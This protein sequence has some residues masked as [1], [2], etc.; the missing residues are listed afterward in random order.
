MTRGKRGQA[1]AP[2]SLFSFQDIMTSVMGIL[3]LIT[4]MMSLELQ[5]TVE[6]VQTPAPQTATPPPETTVAELKQKREQLQAQYEKAVAELSA[7]AEMTGDK[8]SVLRE[9]L[10]RLQTTITEMEQ[11]E[12]RVREIQ[13]QTEELAKQEKSM[14]EKMQETVALEQRASQLRGEIDRLKS[15]PRLTYIMQQGAG[16]SPIL[17]ELSGQLLGIGSH[18][19][20]EPAMWADAKDIDG[21]IELLL[22]LAGNY[23][24]STEYFVLLVK[25]SGFEHYRQVREKLAEKGFDVGTELLDENQYVLLRSE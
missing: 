19:T 11:L 23:S 8:S 22:A 20:Q 12:R 4:L 1:G 7:V 25:P 15:N 3:V 13:T 16:K 10:A 5:E 24:P 21:R 14:A 17:V 2:I 6:Q 18:K 9:Q